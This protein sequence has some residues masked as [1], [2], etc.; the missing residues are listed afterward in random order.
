MIIKRVKKEDAGNYI[1]SAEND[2][3]RSSANVKLEV[4]DAKEN[5]SFV[6]SMIY[7]S[8]SL[9]YYTSFMHYSF[10]FRLLSA[11]RSIA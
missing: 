1:C 11:S 6:Y 3:G 8:Y 9:F 7:L 4:T 2:Y 10:L 5:S